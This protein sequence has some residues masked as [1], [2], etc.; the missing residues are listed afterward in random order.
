MTKTKTVT[1]TEE[2]EH[3]GECIYVEDCG[4]S[5]KTGYKCS[6][7]DRVIKKLWGVIPEWCPLEE[8]KK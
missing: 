5:R 3:C 4:G 2:Y 7:A 1:I 6:K 8:V